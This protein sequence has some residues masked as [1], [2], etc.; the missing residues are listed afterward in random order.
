MRR[1]APQHHMRETLHSERLAREKAV[2]GD[3]EKMREGGVAKFAESPG[4]SI[5]VALRLLSPS[6]PCRCS[7]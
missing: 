3:R 7:H 4:D 1:A 2:T 5:R 6:P